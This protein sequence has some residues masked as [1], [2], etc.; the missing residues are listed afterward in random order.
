LPVSSK[1]PID[2]SLARC[3][4]ARKPSRSRSQGGRGGLRWS[5]GMVAPY[6]GALASCLSCPPYP[7]CL[8]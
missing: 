1:R 2:I 8:L 6:S 7:S 5:G 4:S 3:R